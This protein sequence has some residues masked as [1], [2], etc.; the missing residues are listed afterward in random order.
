MKKIKN[1][2]LIP[3]DITPEFICN[4]SMKEREDLFDKLIE[5]YLLKRQYENVK[6]TYKL[7]NSN[8]GFCS[9]LFKQQ[10]E[11]ND[12][13]ISLLK[14]SKASLFTP[15]PLYENQINKVFEEVI[16]NDID[17][18]AVEIEF[19]P[20]SPFYICKYKASL[21]NQSIV[22]S[23]RNKQSIKRIIQLNKDEYD[24]LNK[25][26]FNV[27]VTSYQFLFCYFNY[28]HS[29]KIDLT[30]LSNKS[31]V[32]YESIILDNKQ[33][34]TM[35][36]SKV[37]FRIN[38]SLVQKEFKLIEKEFINIVKFFPTFEI[39]QHLKD[40]AADESE[41]KN[42]ITLKNIHYVNLSR[43]ILMP[44]KDEA[45]DKLEISNKNLD[46]TITSHSNI[47]FDISHF[48]EKELTNPLD[49]EYYITIKSIE[50]RLNFLKIK[51]FSNEYPLKEEKMEILKFK[52]KLEILQNSISQG[53]LK[54]NDYI[55][56]IKN[57]IEKDNLLIVY[58]KNKLDSESI[59]NDLSNRIK[60]LKKELNDIFKKNI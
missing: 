50:E 5:S 30:E 57:R 54:L 6:L 20:P 37:I 58:F 24:V 7:S 31:T 36:Y 18:H 11:G 19:F 52:E 60:I 48:T 13:T 15:V 14:K 1:L 2:N 16:N 49:I 53:A 29:F 33:K 28:S 26:H 55:D 46:E 12:Q 23:F 41:E 17:L 32:E 10:I 34:P 40:D 35:N 25:N 21:F 3:D 45:I 51:C 8:Q 27:L 47:V 44:T 9:L 42:I 56:S 43:A 22:V 59:L 39:D 38:K 4:V